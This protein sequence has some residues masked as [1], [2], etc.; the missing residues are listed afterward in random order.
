MTEKEMRR[1]VDAFIREAF[2]S[3]INTAE[4]AKDL[5]DRFDA[6]CA[7]NQVPFEISEIFTESGAGE[8]LWMMQGI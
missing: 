6:F 3:G 7:D 2:R 1:Q 8:M 5:L 4:R